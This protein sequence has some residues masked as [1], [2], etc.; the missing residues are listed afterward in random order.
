MALAVGVT[1]ADDFSAI[2]TRVTTEGKIYIVNST[3]GKIFKKA[4]DDKAVEIPKG[5]EEEKEKER[6]KKSAKVKDSDKVKD[7]DKA[8]DGDN[9]KD[10]DK[11]KEKEVA[12]DKEEPTFDNEVQLEL[13]AN[14]RISRVQFN[15]D[16]KRAEHGKPLPDGLSNDMFKK[17]GRGIPAR[18]KTSA[19]D[20]VTDIIILAPKKKGEK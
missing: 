2:I 18:F 20:K 8:K 15:K 3:K 6:P 5:K 14:V 7:G 11:K 9:S 4:D 1:V 13:A 12:K 17:V 16:T 19:D 10:A